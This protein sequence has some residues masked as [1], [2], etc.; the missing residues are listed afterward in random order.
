VVDSSVVQRAVARCLSRR[1]EVVA[2]YVFGSVARRRTRKDSDVDVAVLLASPLPPSRSLSYRLKL[3]TD[4]GSALHRSDVE[5]V[6]LNEASP[7][8]AHRV[9]SKGTLVFERSASARVRFQVRTASRYN[10]L[11]PMFETHIRYLK[12]RVREGRIVG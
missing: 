7:L 5:V 2:A 3:M 8:L 10:D 12:R 1:R 4:L 11:I 9:L 6:V